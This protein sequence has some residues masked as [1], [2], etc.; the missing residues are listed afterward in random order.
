MIDLSHIEKVYDSPSG[1]VRAIKDISLHIN[2]GEIYGIIGLSGAG[3]STLV[4]CI[5]LLERPTSGKV[6]VDGQDITAM[7]ESQ[8]RQARKSI[9]MIFQHFNL[10]SSATVY[11]NVAFPLR[12][13]NTPK[14]KIDKKVTELLE[15]VGLAD[16]ANQYPSQLSG[17]QK[18]RVGIARALASEPKIL[19]C[20]EAT[21]ALDPQTTKAILQLIRDINAKLK[22][23]VVV[24]THEMQVIK[25]ICD[26]VA[27]IDKGVIAEKGNVLE[28]FTNPQQPI[29]REFISVLLSNDLP[30]G[31]RE[32][33]VHQ[34][35]FSGSVLLIRITFIGESANEP[36]ISRLIKNFDLNVGILFGSLDDIKGV[37][38]GRLI[39]SL[40]GRQLE[41][42]EALG[43]VQRQNLKVEV[44][45]YVSRHDSAH[46]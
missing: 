45:G 3:K 15:L 17:G 1:P 27:V 24:I 12:L 13:V 43:Y 38:F 28:V 44:I 33:E 16:K 36:V 30:V 18:Q 41:I 46:Q 4:R 29:T 6:T 22:L 23:T 37:P 32:R 21:S 31:F 5:N 7:S 14:E 35:Q 42:Q 39:I 20:D 26:K 34:E 11:E 10:L 19:L 8:L 9:G 25:D 40:D 2:R